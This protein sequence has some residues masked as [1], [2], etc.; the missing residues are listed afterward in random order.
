[1]LGIPVTTLI[2]RDGQICGRHVGLVNK[3]DLEAQ[4]KALL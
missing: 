1:M 2:S 3:D 4:I